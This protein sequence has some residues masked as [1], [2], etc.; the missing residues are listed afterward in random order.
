MMDAIQSE[1]VL[2]KSL[3]VRNFSID[4]IWVFKTHFVIGL[5]L[6]LIA[7]GGG[8]SSPVTAANELVSKGDVPGA[9]A[10]LK[11]AISAEPSKLLLRFH[12]GQVYSLGFDWDSSEHELKQARD[13]GV[14]EGGRVVLSLARALLRAKKYEQVVKD[15]EVAQAFEPN[16]LAGIHAVRAQAL[17]ALDRFAEGKREV[18]VAEKLDPRNRDVILAKA[19]VLAG[20]RDLVGAMRLVDGLLIVNPRDIDVLLTRADILTVAGRM[21]EAVKV[22]DK[23]IEINSSHAEALVA[24]T[25]LLV[26]SSRIVEANK[27]VDALRRL[28]PKI[29]ALP[30]LRA[31]IHF[32]RG[33]YREAL[34]QAQYA[35]KS[36]KDEGAARLVSGMSNLMLGSP[37]QARREFEHYN[38]SDPRRELDLRLLFDLQSMTMD[39]AGE[40][41]SRDLGQKYAD[42]LRTASVQALFNDAYIRVWSYSK[43]AQWFQNV[44]DA[45]HPDPLALVKLAKQRF[46]RSQLERAS[47]DLLGAAALSVSSTSAEQG[48]VLVLL[49]LNKDMQATE[50]AKALM[51]KAPNSVLGPHL[52]GLVA[53]QQG[54]LDQ[55]AAYL[56]DALDRNPKYLPAVVARARLDVKAGRT[57]QARRRFEAFLKL[58]PKNTPAVVYHALNEAA[59]RRRSEALRLLQSAIET[60]PKA[61]APRMALMMILLVENEKDR[62]LSEAERMLEAQPDNPGALELAGEIQGWSGKSE[63]SIVTLSRLVAAF[64]RIP[65]GHYKLAQAQYEAGRKSESSISLR[66]AVSLPPN[67]PEALG[68]SAIGILDDA[69]TMR[70]LD[71][72]RKRVLLQPRPSVTMQPGGGFLSGPLGTGQGLP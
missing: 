20:G 3:S 53:I 51:T 24:R 41:A 6:L 31:Q 14:V 13:G 21:P 37:V 66:M 23:V 49:A 72:T 45:E 28:Y 5:A 71:A 26:Y 46:S 64:P 16:V 10:K 18:A 59:G 30:Y 27:D 34:E 25:L 11:D 47:V 62:A 4:V 15:T 63:R 8:D 2:R 58:D 67:D 44:G 42:E 36:A 39:G 9:I 29:S 7:C 68:Y 19:C 54:H 69:R 17:L 60:E 50:A 65:E 52:L 22:L 35:L 48:L 55:A 43:L 12:L 57:E 40:L 56:D 32:W 70:A 38:E 33:E 1:D 61:I